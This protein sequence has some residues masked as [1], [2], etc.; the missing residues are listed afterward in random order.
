MENEL[1]MKNGRRLRVGTG[2]A[3]E[4]E[5]DGNTGPRDNTGS[6]KLADQRLQPSPNLEPEPEKPEANNT[7]S[8]G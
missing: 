1:I 5:W 7:G 6:P 3:S 8:N 2:T 4:E